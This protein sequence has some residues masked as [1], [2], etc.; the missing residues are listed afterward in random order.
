MKKKRP[1]DLVEA[2]RSLISDGRLRNIHLLFVGSG[3]LD[4]ELRAG[5][6]CRL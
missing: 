2:A 6:P 1:L 3:E 5:M 4:S